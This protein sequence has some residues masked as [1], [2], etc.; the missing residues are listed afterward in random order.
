MKDRWETW[1]QQLTQT[2]IHL[3]VEDDR[4]RAGERLVAAGYALHSDREG[5]V[6]I[7]TVILKQ[8]KRS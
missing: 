1:G 8:K 6:S 5:A 4:A 7:S 3:Q 2:T